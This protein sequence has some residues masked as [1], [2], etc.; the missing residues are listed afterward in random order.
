[1]GERLEGRVRFVE[2]RLTPE[3]GRL[4]AG[5]TLAANER[6]ATATAEREQGTD[7][8]LWCAAEAT[9]TALR[10]V[11]DLGDD[12]LTLKEVV[13]FSLSGSPAVAVSLRVRVEGRKRRLLGLAQAE[14]DRGRAAALSVL[15]ATNR[16][17][18]G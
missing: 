17:A 3:G 18:G 4:R 15:S 8:D 2:C 14:T 11:L 16:F 1:M 9:V 5:V 13:L 7:A 12:E 10:Q 6:T